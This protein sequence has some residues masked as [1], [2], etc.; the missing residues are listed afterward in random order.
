MM[1][2]HAYKILWE[3]LLF[4]KFGI[5]SKDISLAWFWAR[6]V[7][8]TPSLAYPQ[9]GFLKFANALVSRIKKKKGKVLFNNQVKQI[10]VRKNGKVMVDKQMFDKAI[11]TLPSFFFTQ[12]APQLP[13]NY[14]EKLLSL[15]GLG[16]I[17]LVL[18]LK[19]PFFKDGTY[20]LNICDSK[21]PVMGIIEHTNFMNK[22]YY[23]NEHLVYLGNYLPHDHLF[24]KMDKNDLLKI[25]DPIL[26]KI[27]KDYASSII[28]THLFSVPFAQ[29]IIPTN[30]SK[31]LPPFKTPLK[32]V[33]LANIQQV[34]PWDRGTNYAV[35]LGEKIAD[36]ILEQ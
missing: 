3:P 26:K 4:R 7:K 23:N 18:R 30:Y 29:P 36:I 31:I 15:K 17:N 28:E 20:W 35:E 10:I 1:G 9:G 24:M 27:N 13:Q 11:V 5:F 33:Y 16:A 22:K 25:Y 32:N 2:K 14:K 21:Y 34:Y 8:R 12:I 19:K 6:I